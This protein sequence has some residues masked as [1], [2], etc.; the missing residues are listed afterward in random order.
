MSPNDLTDS[1][2]HHHHCVQWPKTTSCWWPQGQA[3]WGWEGVEANPQLRWKQVFSIFAFCLYFEVSK[4]VKW[5]PSAS[6]ILSQLP[7]SDLSRHRDQK[8]MDH[9]RT[10]S[11]M[12]F[13]QTI[14]EQPKTLNDWLRVCACNCRAKPFWG[15]S[16]AEAVSGRGSVAMEVEMGRSC[17]CWRSVLTIEH[18]ITNKN[19]T[20]QN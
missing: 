12:Q 20:E 18:I 2:H 3:W 5:S 16:V 6:Q 13:H 10:S 4:T 14:H 17:H 7:C 1:Y 8:W 15:V 9:M 19:S 11:C